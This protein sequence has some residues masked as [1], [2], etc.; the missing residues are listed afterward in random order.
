MNLR[1]LERN[2]YHRK[3]LFATRAEGGE[4]SGPNKPATTRDLSK[5]CLSW[6]ILG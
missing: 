1:E 5:P 4:P 3:E 6:T 2:E